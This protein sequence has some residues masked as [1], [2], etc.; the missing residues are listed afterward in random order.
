MPRMSAI[1]DRRHRETGTT[2]I[3]ALVVVAI[4]MLVTLIGFPRLQQGLLTLSQRETAVTLEARLREARA[5]ALIENHPIIFS[6]LAGGRTYGWRNALV[7]SAPG[8]TVASVNGPIGF[9]GDGTSTGGAVWVTAGRRS[10]LVGVDA[11]NGAVGFW[12]K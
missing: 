4:T 3:E 1:G 6:V 9:F 7:Q 2:L 8:V 10:Y 5:T 12:K 11:A